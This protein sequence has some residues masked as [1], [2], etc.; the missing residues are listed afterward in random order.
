MIGFQYSYHLSKTMAH[1]TIKIRFTIHVYMYTLMLRLYH[2]FSMQLRE[3]IPY[4]L[5]YSNT[6]NTWNLSRSSYSLCKLDTHTQIQMKSPQ[7]FC[8]QNCNHYK[9]NIYYNNIIDQQPL[10]LSC[11]AAKDPL[12]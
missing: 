12:N 10:S 9:C 8:I 1:S 4:I 5:A 7:I 2:L 11:N 6:L 3:A